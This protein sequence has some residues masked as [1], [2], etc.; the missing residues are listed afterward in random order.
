MSYDKDPEN[1]GLYWAGYV[2]TRTAYDFVPFDL[3]KTAEM[4]RYG[5]KLNRQALADGKIKLNP[6]AQKNIRGI[7]GQLWSEVLIAPERLEAATFPKLLGLAERAWAIQPTW[8]TNPNETQRFANLASD[9]NQFTNTIGQKEM[10]RLDYLTGGVG[11][12]IPPAG[13]KIDNGKLYANTAFPGLSI[14]YTLD[15]SEPTSQSLEYTGPIDV[16]G[17]VRLKV[18]SEGGNTSRSVLVKK[19]LV[20]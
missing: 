12:H 6:A 17:D 20:D 10:T 16:L 18:F 11:Y 2:N 13:G 9:W 15:G 1:A 19:E 14:R 7:Q 4:G 5:E 3:F 8:A